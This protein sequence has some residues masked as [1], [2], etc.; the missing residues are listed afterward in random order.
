MRYG[1]VQKNGPI[2][3]VGVLGIPWVYPKEVQISLKSM[4]ILNYPSKGPQ[5]ASILASIFDQKSWFF[6]INQ[7]F[8]Y[9]I[10]FL[11]KIS[12]R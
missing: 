6:Y 8:G 1:A 11:R 7:Y 10:L 9:Q 12:S 4:N 5:T 2:L 3:E